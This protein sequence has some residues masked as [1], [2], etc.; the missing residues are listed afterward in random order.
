[1]DGKA[2]T[3]CVAKTI[4]DSDWET[5]VTCKMTVSSVTVG[6]NGVTV[7]SI[8][9][10]TADLNETALDYVMTNAADS[11]CAPKTAVDSNKLEP[12]CVAMT[13]VDSDHESDATEK[14]LSTV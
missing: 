11:Q 10:M 13:S 14:R 6:S 7:D 3:N 9:I 1:L 2:T 5:A 4:V 12:A 8:M